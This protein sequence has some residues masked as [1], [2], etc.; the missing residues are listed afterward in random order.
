LDNEPSLAKR[1]PVLLWMATYQEENSKNYYEK[2][3]DDALKSRDSNLIYLVIMKFLKST[4]LD[5]SYTF[6]LMSQNPIT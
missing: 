1:V 4:K 3:L 6:T 2:A 5:E